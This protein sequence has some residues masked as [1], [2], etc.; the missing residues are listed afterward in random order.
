MV[1]EYGAA[2]RKLMSQP[3]FDDAPIEAKSKR[4]Q[5]VINAARLRARAIF[6]RSL[7]KP[8]NQ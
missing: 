3:T 8:V 7:G 5:A 6:K 2:I 1:R 4:L